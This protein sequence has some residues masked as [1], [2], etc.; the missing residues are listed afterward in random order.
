MT[1]QKFTNFHAIRLWNFQNICNEIGW[2]RFFCTTLYVSSTM[3][4]VQMSVCLYI[5]VLCL[6]RSSY[7]EQGV[8]HKRQYN[9]PAETYEMN[10]NYFFFSSS[11]SKL[12]Q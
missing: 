9:M 7:W 6:P 11:R 8:S 12:I 2:H 5:T 4:S 1:V 3:S 10:H